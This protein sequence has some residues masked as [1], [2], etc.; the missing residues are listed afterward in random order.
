M[1]FD[2]AGLIKSSVMLVLGLVLGL[3]LYLSTEIKYV[4][5]C[6]GLEDLVLGL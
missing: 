1:I 2:P 5:L 3:G 6:L 4:V